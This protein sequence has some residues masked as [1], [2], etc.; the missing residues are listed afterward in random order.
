[1]KKKLLLISVFLF[2]GLMA[3]GAKVWAADLF[4]RVE[5]AC[6]SPT[7][8]ILALDS[9][10]YSRIKTCPRG[11]RKVVL[12]QEAGEGG[13]SGIGTV[14]TVPNVVFMDGSTVLMTDGTVKYFSSGNWVKNE[15]KSVL[16]SGVLVTDIVTWGTDFFTTQGGEI[17]QWISDPNDET[18]QLGWWTLIANPTLL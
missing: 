11:T 6:Q 5:Y 7:G 17:Y 15:G 14:I 10:G 16:P 9:D 18:Y 3:V 2:L 8:V 1:M 4:P 13:G 12:G